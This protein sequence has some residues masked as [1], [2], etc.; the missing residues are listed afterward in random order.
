MA[1]ASSAATKQAPPVVVE[2]EKKPTLLDDS[3]II[4]AD[5]IAEL[6][7][8]LGDGEGFDVTVN[9]LVGRRLEWL[10]D[11]SP[12]D[13]SVRELRAYLRDEHGGGDFKIVVRKN[14]AFVSHKTIS[15]RAKK[16][17]SFNPGGVPQAVQGQAVDRI[18]ELIAL[19][20]QQMAQSQKDM[21]LLIMDSQKAGMQQQIDVMKIMMESGGKNQPL[22]VVGVLSLAKDLFKGRDN[23]VELLLKGIELAKELSPEKPENEG[24]GGLSKVLETLGGPL[25]QLMVEHQKSKNNPGEIIEQPGGG[26]DQ[27]SEGDMNIIQ[28]A[29]LRAAAAMFIRAAEKNGDVDAYAE[30]FCDQYGDQVPDEFIQDQDEFNKI[31]EAVPEA[32]AHR[33]WFEKL[34]VACDKILFEGEV[35][36]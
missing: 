34:R 16:Q 3:E 15:I 20:Q 24:A 11:F 13:M 33:E 35:D 21:Q 30:I 29:Q 17:N 5:E 2:V 36:Q 27:L 4:Q 7:G 28:Q 12:S 9:A 26:G 25:A 6:M 32:A 31:F 14:G 8:E 10:F 22:D 23:S 18:G 19:M 1:R